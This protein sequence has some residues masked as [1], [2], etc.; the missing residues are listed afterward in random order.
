M[1]RLPPVPI[2][3]QARLASKLQLR[4]DLLGADLRPVALQLLGH[5]LRQAG[6]RALTHLRAR[7]ADHAAH[8]PGRTT[9]QRLSL[10]AVA[11]G[12]APASNGADQPS[13]SVPATA[14]V[15]TMNSRRD[16]SSS[17][18]ETLVCS[19]A[20]PQALRPAMMAAARCT[21]P[22]GCAGRCRSGRCWSSPR[23]C[24]HRSACGSSPAGP[25][26]P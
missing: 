12:C 19:S 25:R 10:A 21:A 9:T 23:R 11:R 4:R 13:T 17:A 5:Q 18:S 20:A 3:P 16:G 7:D 15:V 1:P 14:P 6:E 22:R 24:R 2:S 8:H 26:P